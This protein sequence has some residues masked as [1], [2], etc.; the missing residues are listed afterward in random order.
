MSNVT[1]QDVFEQF[2]PTIADRSFSDVQLNA[3]RC[4]RNC[5]TAEMGAHV[6][7]CESCHSTYIHYN[8][9]KNRH[10][11]MCQGMNI[12]EWIDLRREDVLDAP[13]F[14]TVFSVPSQLY[15]L[16]YSNQ[17]LL[18]DALYHAA[19]KTLSELSKDPKHFGARI[20]YICVLHTWG[21]MLNYHPHL[22]VIVLGGGLDKNNHWKDKGSKFFLPVKVMSPVF[23]RYYLSELKLLHDTGKL[24]YTG[25]SSYLKNDYE[26]KELMNKLYETDWIV[27]S[28]RTF[29]GAQEVFQYLGKYTHRIAISNR[30]IVDMDE[31][32]VT[33]NAKDYKT[34]G[35]YHPLTISGEVFLSRFLLH[36]LPL[37]FVKIR[38]YGILACRCKKD[39]ITLCRNLIGCQQYISR[40]RNKT[41]AEK[42]KILY[43]RD[44]CICTK[45]GSPLISHTVRGRYMLC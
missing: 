40:V 29:A 43:N 19:N 13:Y 18:Y 24:K 28:K 1:I 26:F 12:D 6:S 2:L 10:C 22:H 41:V 14:H 34:D 37:G 31:E 27:Y 9:C 35:K 11:P 17:K 15:A 20:G 25:Q 44:I 5:R 45:C 32:T 36:V 39:N 16:V 30:R 4:I 38:Y 42:L 21:S 23:R 3:I 33:F 7:E 8:S